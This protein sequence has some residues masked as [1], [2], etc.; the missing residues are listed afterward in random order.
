[1]SEPVKVRKIK[2]PETRRAVKP[3][4]CVDWSDET[5]QAQLRHLLGL[6]LS[7]SKVAAKMN[8]SKNAV[9]GARR[10]LGLGAGQSPILP[11]G[12]GKRPRRAPN[13][14]PIRLTDLPT[15]PVEVD[16]PMVPAIIWHPPKPLAP[17][18]PQ[19]GCSYQTWRTKD[20]AYWEAIASGRYLQCDE[21]TTNGEQYCEEHLRLCT[22]VRPALVEGPGARVPL[23]LTKF[24]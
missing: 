12:S 9:V 23:S 14:K 13:P 4:D 10:R 17:C 3:E 19:R 15:K 22:N 20:G 21:P 8:L 11:K 24:K 1:M 6:G 7:M 18:K 16:A 2:Y 5:R